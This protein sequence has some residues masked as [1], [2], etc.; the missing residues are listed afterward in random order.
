MG[1]GLGA[2][3]EEA[4]KSAVK[5]DPKRVIPAAQVEEAHAFSA[6]GL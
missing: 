2:T 4:A 5:T 6:E 1:G 3:S